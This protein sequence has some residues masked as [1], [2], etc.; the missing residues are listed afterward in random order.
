M[1]SHLKAIFFAYDCGYLQTHFKFYYVHWP[2]A[3]IKILNKKTLCIFL[4]G[5]SSYA[6]VVHLVLYSHSTVQKKIS[7]EKSYLF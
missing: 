1:S 5:C 2:C 4:M 6:A 3:V 7:Q